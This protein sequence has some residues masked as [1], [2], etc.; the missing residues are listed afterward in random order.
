MLIMKQRITPRQWKHS[1]GEGNFRS[2]N[3]E[4]SQQDCLILT[5]GSLPMMMRIFLILLLVMMV[6]VSHQ[7]CE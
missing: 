6:M 2:Y 4:D 3:G 1:S 5:M 7:C